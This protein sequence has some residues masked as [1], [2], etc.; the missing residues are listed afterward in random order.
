M[1]YKN[2]WSIPADVRRS[3][4]IDSGYSGDVRRGQKRYPANSG[5][6]WNCCPAARPHYRGRR[7]FQPELG[8]P[9][10]I[11]SMNMLVH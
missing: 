10:R 4:N 8:P 3:Q 5:A 9:G 11:G 6:R 7:T 2:R 1:S